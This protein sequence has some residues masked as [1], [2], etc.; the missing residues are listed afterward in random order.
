MTPYSINAI[1]SRCFNDIHVCYMG[2]NIKS[3][4]SVI[5]KRNT[6]KLCVRVFTKQVQHF[7][8]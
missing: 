2:P 8:S 7:C 6:E 4:Y 3:T 1:F 5:D